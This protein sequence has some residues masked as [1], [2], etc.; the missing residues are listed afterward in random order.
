MVIATGNT[1]AK[2]ALVCLERTWPKPILFRDLI[3]NARERASEENCQNEARD[4][5]EFFLRAYTMGFAELHAHQPGF[6]TEVSE[7]PRASPLARLLAGRGEVFPTLRHVG[8]RF[9]DSLSRELLR[10]LDGEHDRSALLKELTALA[11]SGALT[12]HRQGTPIADLPEAEKTLADELE[13]NLR[14][15]GRLGLLVG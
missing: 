3:E 7:R 5:A 8:Y 12:V 2:A 11:Q 13:T 1:L 14:N 15:V 6:V 9:E 4:L 10:L